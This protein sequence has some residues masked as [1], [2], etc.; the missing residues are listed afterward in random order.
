MRSRAPCAAVALAAIVAEAAAPDRPESRNLAVIAV[1]TG[2]APNI[3]GRLDDQAWRAAPVF[4]AFVQSF[5]DAGRPP[6]EWTDLRVLYDDRFLYVGIRALD[7]QPERIVRSLG[8]RDDPP[9]SD[10]V[11][12]VVDATRSRR[13]AYAFAVN[14]GGVLKDGLYFDDNQ[15]NQDWDGVWEARAAI[16]ANGWSA[17]FAIPLSL[18]GL[19]DSAPHLWGFHVRRSLPRTN[20]EI[21]TALIPQSATQFVSRFLELGGVEGLAARSSI[22][23]VPYA[24]AR[25]SLA[26]QYEDPARPRP[27]IFNPSMDIGADLQASVTRNLS[28]TAALNPDFGQVEADRLV[29][30]LSNVELFF[31]EKRPFFTQ[32]LDLFVPVGAD[33]EGRAPQMLFYSRR[34]GLE[35][36]I[37]GAA[38][39]LGRS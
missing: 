4:D 2:A 13:T 17:E 23:I 10:L 29:I 8:R 9:A 7:R 32:G 34:I 35:T 26:P 5:P 12:V 36:P 31:P 33:Q 21:D 11:T 18:L 22:A 1:R 24:A 16:D 14:A 19:T 25:A 37:L 27:Q 6:T 39:V 30:N 20:E 3:D 15:F 38:K 28:L